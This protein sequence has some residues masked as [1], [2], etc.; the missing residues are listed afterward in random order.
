MDVATQAKIATMTAAGMSTRQIEAV[1]GVDH[2]VVAYN[3]KFDSVRQ[4]VD[5]SQA[6]IIKD[7][8]QSTAENITDLIKGYKLN[9]CS[10]RRKAAEKEHGFKATIRIAEATGLIPAQNQSI[11]IQQI[12]NDQ[13]TDIPAQ[14]QQVLQALQD[15]DSTGSLV[16]DAEDANA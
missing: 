10:S 15:K 11:Y 8:I 16:I 5:F 2:A 9:D 12:Y 3:L 4:L 6:K 13:R 7:C 1:T 14:I